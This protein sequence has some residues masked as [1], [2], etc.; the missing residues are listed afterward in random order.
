MSEKKEK[1]DLGDKCIIEFG[2]DGNIKIGENCNGKE[3]NNL[4]IAIFNKFNRWTDE[5]ETDEI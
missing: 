4:D 3:I 2:K 5:D 1:L